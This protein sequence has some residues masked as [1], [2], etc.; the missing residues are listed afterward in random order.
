MD[1]RVKLEKLT[2][3]EPDSHPANLILPSFLG[4]HRKQLRVRRA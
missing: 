2:H 1:P 3:L 4:A